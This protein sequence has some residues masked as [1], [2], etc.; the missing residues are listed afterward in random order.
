MIRL[1]RFPARFPVLLALMLAALLIG[2][3]RPAAAT[4]AP[5]PADA[6]ASPSESMPLIV[7]TGNAFGVAL[8]D[9][10]VA[11]APGE[12]VVISPY[13]LAAALTMTAQGAEGETAEALA[14]RLL[15]AGSTLAQ[16][17]RAH[18]EAAEALRARTGDITLAIAN[19]VWGS[20]TLPWRE[21]FL[22]RLR[23]RFGADIRLVDFAEAGTV[24]RIN[25]WVAEETEG[26]IPSLVDDLPDNTGMVLTNAVYFRGFW[27][28]PFDAERTQPEAFILAGGETRNVPMMRRYDTRY[29]YAEAETF[30]AVA[31][32]YGDGSV[33]M[34]VLVPRTGPEGEALATPATLAA[35]VGE[36]RLQPRPGTVALPR[37]DL[38]FEAALKEAM[39]GLG[40]ELAFSPQRADFS[41]MAEVEP[42][43][44]Y[45]DNVLHKT[46]LTLDEEG[47]EAAAVTGVV[48][49]VTSAV[50]PAAPFTLV[51]DHPFVFAIRHIGTNALLFL[52]HVADPGS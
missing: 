27:T 42:G 30:Q 16:A 26:M 19:A 36:V 10:L 8:F 11:A 43:V 2:P 41:G 21:S 24:G 35:A 18:A 29:R 7:S 51:A 4:E 20:E 28:T 12:T 14:S 47:T 37:L 25:E 22:E 1:S 34:L 52:G 40:L 48:V 6:D 33:E 13:S 5:M 15:P 31:L 9:A 50:Q 23:N 38:A 32:P 46:A 39:S 45:L 17:A 3:A 49:G 44:L